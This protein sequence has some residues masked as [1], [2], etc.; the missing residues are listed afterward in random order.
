MVV[1]GDVVVN[2]SPT[3]RDS[4]PVIIHALFI[5][6]WLASNRQPVLVVTVLLITVLVQK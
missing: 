2:E 4:A 6:W 1:G 5:Y 3:V